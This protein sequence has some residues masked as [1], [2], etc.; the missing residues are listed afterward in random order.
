M[1]LG[2][3]SEKGGFIRKHICASIPRGAAFNMEHT[4]FHAHVVLHPARTGEGG[5]KQG[6]LEGTLGLC[7]T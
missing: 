5:G 1:A 4:Q 7:V 6:T 2:S 3:K